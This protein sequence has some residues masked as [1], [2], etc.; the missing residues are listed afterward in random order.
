VLDTNKE[1]TEK[2]YLGKPYIREEL[3]LI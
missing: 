3:E 2:K 1:L